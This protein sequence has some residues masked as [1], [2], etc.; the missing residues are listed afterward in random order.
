MNTDM[1]LEYLNT[2][3]KEELFYKEYQ[4]QKRNPQNFQHYLSS[5][6]ITEIQDRHLIIPELQPAII[7]RLMQDSEYFAAASDKSVYLS[8][9][10]RYTPAFLHTHVFFEIIYVLSGSCHHHVFHNDYLM[11]EGDLCLLSPSVTHSIYVDDDSIVINILIRRSTIEEI[12]YNALRGNSIIS[13]F[14]ASSIYMK[15]YSTY[16]MFHT[17]SDNSVKEAI[18][19][20]LVEQFQED[21]YTDH[22]ISGMLMLFF[23]KLV[24][25]YKKTAEYPPTTKIS[26][27]ATNSIFNYMLEHSASV[28]LSAIAEQMNYTVP[29][30][31]KYIKENTGYTYSQL[32]KKIRFQKAENYLLN[33]SLSI[34]KISELLGYE[35]TENFI[36]AFKK[37]YGISA[38]QFRTQKS[39]P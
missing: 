20:M 17:F 10:N 39:A 7:P 13:D 26:G 5:L 6:N 38:T 36:R 2:Y 23:T 8:K 29:Y 3:N 15:D 11:T 9:H 33:S 34:S 21:E 22:I 1:I 4:N 37:E 27:K 31:S 12:F 24:R 28:T 14:L 16:L 25:K 30:C 19:E 18:L 32:L 35:N